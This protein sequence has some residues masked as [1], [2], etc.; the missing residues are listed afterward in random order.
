MGERL[1]AKKSSHQ[2]HFT[3]QKELV[4][5]CQENSARIN[6]LEE[7]H[8]ELQASCRQCLEAEKF[9]RQQHL[10]SQKEL[11]NKCQDNN[12]RINELEELHK[13]LQASYRDLFTLHTERLRQKGLKEYMMNQK[14]R[15][16]PGNYKP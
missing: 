5:Q 12:T 15:H 2:Q 1:E 14:T 13:A 10:T 9:S 7:L 4:S 3:S 8:E 6:E 16:L 11:V